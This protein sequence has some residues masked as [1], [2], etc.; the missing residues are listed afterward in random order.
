MT[1]GS[2]EQRRLARR[3]RDEHVEAGAGDRACRERLVERVLVDEPA[4]GDV[5]DEGRRLHARELLGAD[6]AG[7]LGRLRHVDR[8]EVAAL[9]QLVEGHQLHAELL[10]PRGRDVRVVGD[11]LGAERLQA[12]GD[13]CADAA[14]SDD[15]DGLLVELDAG[16]VRPL[17]LP[18][19][20]RR[21]R[22]G[23]VTGEAQ[24]V[25]DGELGGRDDVRGRCV[26]DHDARR[27]GGLDVDVVEADARARDDLEVRRGRDRLGV[28]LRGGTHEDRVRLGECRQQRRAV[29]AVDDADVEVGPEGVDGGGREFFGDQHDRL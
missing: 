20:E 7:R 13:E 10:G 22:G 6:H 17:P 23:D 2:A 4:A 3:L 8:D 19:C 29:G 9:E 5:D 26:H 15:A 27:R 24:D 18:L 21:V 1:F 25:P 28:D 11:D 14:E 12:G 16:V